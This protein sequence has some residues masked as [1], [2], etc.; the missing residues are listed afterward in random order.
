MIQKLDA[1]NYNTSET[2]TIKVPITI[3]YAYNSRDFERVDGKFEH[4]GEFYRLV[5]QRLYR[6][7]LYYVCVKDHTSKRINQA[8]I[9]YVKTMTDEPVDQ[10]KSA[11]TLPGFS[12]DFFSYAFSIDHISN[13]W[14]YEVV[15]NTFVTVFIC[16]EY[17]S[18][19]F[20]PPECA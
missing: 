6:D 13:G 5:K 17:P 2:I 19:I 12:K 9:S 14:E 11:H 20:H 3:P 7:T 18:S 10:Q 16:D 8:L 1:N 4:N 15:K